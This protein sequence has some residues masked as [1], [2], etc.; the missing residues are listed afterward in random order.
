MKNFISLILRNVPRKYLQALSVPALR[1][2]SLFLRGEGSVCEIC[3]NHYRRFLPYGRLRARSN[4]LCPGCLSLERHR[5]IFRF[6]KSQTD[7]F[8]KKTDVLHI[9]PEI[10]F[11][12]PFRI[13][14]G[15]GYVTAD[16]ESPWADV[17]MDIHRMPF[18]DNTFEFV[19]C[20]HVLEHVEDDFMAMR[21]IKRVLRPGGRA[22]LQVPFFAP[23]P[24]KTFE[25]ATV[26][27]ESER[28]RLFG[29]KDHVRRY[30]KDYPSR[31]EASGLMVE[32][33]EFAF[34]LLHDQC[35]QLGIVPE[36]IYLGLKK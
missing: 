17:K 30:G 13:Q 5:L 36:V 2:A 1:L 16:L 29:Q 31:I 21:E 12:K 32:Q 23:V 33:E 18:P 3:G 24:D 7:F 10:C 6:L 26:K 35:R 20:N 19:I 11:L 8:N 34:E 27:N 25:D 14:H 15:G 22:I 4:A 9:A 28:E